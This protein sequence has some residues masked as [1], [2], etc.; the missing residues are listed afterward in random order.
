MPIIAKDEFSRAELWDKFAQGV[1]TFVFVTILLALVGLIYIFLGVVFGP[2]QTFNQAVRRDLEDS[3]RVVVLGALWVGAIAGSAR[4][5]RSPRS[6]E[7]AEL[8]AMRQH[9]GIGVHDD[10][11]LH[12]AV[13]SKASFSDHVAPR[14][15]AETGVRRSDIRLPD[16][17]EFAVHALW[18]SDAMSGSHDRRLS[19]A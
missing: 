6:A 9:A 13:T 12:E 3:V 7:F 16:Q 10:P 17:D 8:R 5:I 4:M 11:S 1:V 2:D 19:A 15:V 14:L 18:A